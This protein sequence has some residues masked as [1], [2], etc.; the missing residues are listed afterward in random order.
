VSKNFCFLIPWLKFLGNIC[1]ALVNTFYSTNIVAKCGQNGSKCRKHALTCL[2][3]ELASVNI[4]DCQVFKITA[5]SIPRRE[6][7]R[8][9]VQETQVY[10]RLIWGSV[11]GSLMYKY[12][13]GLPD[14]RFSLCPFN[15]GGLR[16]ASCDGTSGK[17]HVHW[18]TKNSSSGCGS[19][20]Y[21]HDFTFC[22]FDQIQ[23]LHNYQIYHKTKT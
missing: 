3:F 15:G 20:N 11:H 14:L 7:Q 4:S 17:I 12:R 9:T 23:N 18:M 10:V 8:I 5:L 19:G 13:T 2:R 6:F 16:S 21:M 22:I 1:F